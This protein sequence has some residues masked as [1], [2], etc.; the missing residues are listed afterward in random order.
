MFVI[1]T[2]PNAS[3]EINGIPFED[4]KDGKISK[5]AVSAEV[6]EAFARIEGY[7][8]VD[9]K[10]PKAAKKDS[11]PAEAPVMEGVPPVA[12]GEQ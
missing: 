10:Q 11:K 4:H 9:A 5:G 1:C 12:E 6:A 3:D 8:V 7:K 2:L